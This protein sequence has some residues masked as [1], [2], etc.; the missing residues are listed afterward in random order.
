VLRGL[1]SLTVL[2]YPPLRERGAERRGARRTSGGGRSGKEGVVDGATALSATM[3]FG[4]M[5]V[6]VVV[7]AIVAWA[8]SGDNVDTAFSGFVWT[9]LLVGV[10]AGMIWGFGAWVLGDG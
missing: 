1:A 2:A 7:V 10:V 9:L 3:V 4:A 5:V 8:T 6:V